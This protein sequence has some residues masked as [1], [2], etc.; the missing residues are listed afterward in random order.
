MV[1]SV[2]FW[3][4][5]AVGNLAKLPARYVHYLPHTFRTLPHYL[6]KWQTMTKL[7]GLYKVYINL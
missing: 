1:F 2:E 7:L 4:N 3:T 6:E 5:C